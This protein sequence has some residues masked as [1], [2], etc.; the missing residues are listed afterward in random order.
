LPLLLPQ[1]PLL[2]YSANTHQETKSAMFLL[3]MLS[4]LV[5]LIM[6]LLL[7]TTKR[8]GL[9]RPCTH[10]VPNTA[11]FLQMTSKLRLLPASPRH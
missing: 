3:L 10:Q 9:W 6:M 1:L 8:A 2:P 4:L 5:L 7:L 11:K